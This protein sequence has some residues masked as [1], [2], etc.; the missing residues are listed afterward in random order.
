MAIERCG[1]PSPDEAGSYI[2]DAASLGTIGSSGT[3]R[4]LAVTRL[5]RRIMHVTGLVAVMYANIPIEIGML[6]F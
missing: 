4:S 1:E 5:T 6:S 2:R 3:Y